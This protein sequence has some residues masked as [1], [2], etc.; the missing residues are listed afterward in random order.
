MQSISFE[1][2]KP[3][4][5]ESLAF[6][7]YIFSSKVLISVSGF[8]KVLGNTAYE[9]EFSFIPCTDKDNHPR[10]NLRCRAGYVQGVSRARAEYRLQRTLSLQYHSGILFAV[11]QDMSRHI[12]FSNV[13]LI[14]KL[15]SEQKSTIIIITRI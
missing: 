6:L 12:H 8:K 2:N 14:L 7:L 10:D 9:G 3:I 13:S 15:I 11:N 1:T 5:T 4:T